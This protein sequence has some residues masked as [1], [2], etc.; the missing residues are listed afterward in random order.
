MMM[1]PLTMEI[2]LLIDTT[3]TEWIKDH[4]ISDDDTMMM[5]KKKYTVDVTMMIISGTPEVYKYI[6]RLH[7]VAFATE[8]LSAKLKEF[9]HH[10]QNGA[11]G[12]ETLV[13]D[14]T[15]L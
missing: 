6:Q 2:S 9:C 10:V 4:D 3:A 13:K 14:K 8:L 11:E 15:S 5:M 12:N 1:T 7:K